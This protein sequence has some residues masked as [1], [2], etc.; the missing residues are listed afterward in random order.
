MVRFKVTS[1]PTSR[2]TNIPDNS[3][4]VSRVTMATL[5]RVTGAETLN[6][7]LMAIL[8]HKPNNGFSCRFSMTLSK[9]L[10]TPEEHSRSSMAQ[11][12]SH[13]QIQHNPQQGSIYGGTQ[14]QQHGHPMGSPQIRPPQPPH[15]PQ[16]GCGPG[17]G[18]GGGINQNT[19]SRAQPNPNQQFP[20]QLPPQGLP[21]MTLQVPLTLFPP[22]GPPQCAPQ[23]PPQ[24]APQFTNNS[25]QWRQLLIQ[26][27]PQQGSI[28][29]GG[30][31]PQQ[32][33]HPK[34]NPQ[35]RPPQPPHPPQG[36]CGQGQGFQQ[37]QPPL[38]SQGG[39]GNGPIGGGEGGFNQCTPPMSQPNLNQQFPPQFPLQGPPQLKPQN[40]LTLFP[41]QGPPQLKPQ[42]PPTLF[43]PQGPPQFAPQVPPAQFPPQGAPQIV[44]LVP[45]S[46]FPP[47]GL[48]PYPPHVPQ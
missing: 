15:P 2:K 39:L 26:H 3:S 29:A 10:Y 24:G 36:G 8:L 41:P 4:K 48:P 5:L 40:P 38:M 32:H 35:I 6:K 23:F 31:Q 21:Q 9:V 25:Q 12:W 34:G 19:P 18:G 43:P 1:I 33:G 42:N 30:T 16:G 46:Q 45:S 28:Y 44:L 47:Q 7:D 20:P 37:H 13:L 14:P 11:Q 27:D 22:Q 17:R